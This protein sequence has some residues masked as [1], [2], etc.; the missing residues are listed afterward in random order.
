MIWP[1]AKNLPGAAKR[2]PSSPAKAF[3]EGDARA[4]NHVL[5]KAGLNPARPGA[6]P[7][8]NKAKA[9]AFRALRRVH[10][11]QPIKDA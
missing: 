9:L 3:A 8:T 1:G 7:A 2:S 11:P 10:T 4:F 5:R 6:F